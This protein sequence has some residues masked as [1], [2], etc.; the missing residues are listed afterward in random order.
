MGAGRARQAS[1]RPTWGDESRAIR[2]IDMSQRQSED[3]VTETNVAMVQDAGIDLDWLTR[4]IDYRNFQ[5]CVHCGLCTA[6]CPTYV[7]TS[8]E[9]DSPR[10]RIY[11]MRAVTDGRLAI[12]SDVRR[13]LELCLDCR[14]CESAC[15]SGVRYGSLIEPFKIAMQKDAPN[16]A[17]TSLLQRLILRHLFPYSRRVSAALAPARLLQR[18]GVLDRAERSGLTRLLPPTLRRMIAML[19]RLSGSRTKLPEVLPPIGPKRARVALF[20]GCVADAMCPETNAATARVLQ[21]NGCEVV[22][23]RNQVCCGAIH[24]HSG[25]EEPALE[26]A[27]QNMNTF[28]IQG[29]DAIIVN[30]AGCGAMLKDYA[31]ILPAAERDRGDRFVSKVKDVSEFLVALGP[32]APQ[33]PV[34]LKVT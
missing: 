27:R 11:L 7:E 18:I 3:M 20:L 2:G 12:G 5:E 30:A 28:E 29:F 16:G 31:H 32:I 23:P 6:S 13:H 17:G 34:N 9:N 19:P 25:V 22:I 10:G 1:A 4:K 15:P 24:Y 26:F 14:A 21:Q 33:H 8:N